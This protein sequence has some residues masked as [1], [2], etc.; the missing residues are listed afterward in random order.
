MAQTRQGSGRLCLALALAAS[1]LF[2]ASCATGSR[3][4]PATPSPSLRPSPAPTVAESNSAP[5]RW[6]YD[7]TKGTGQRDPGP[8]FM[9]LPPGYRIETVVS[10]LR[11]PTSIAFTPDGRLL[12]AQQSGAIRVV[13]DGRLRREPWYVVDAYIPVSEQWFAELGLVG[14]TV[15]PEFEENGYVYVY[16]TTKEPERRTVLA[17][18][19]DE[20]GRGV[21]LE[22][23][24]SLEAA[25]ECC[26]IAGSLRFAPDGSLFV[27]VGDHQLETEA[28]NVGSPFGAALRI[29]REGSAR[30][31]NPFVNRRGADARVYAYGLRNAYD[32]AIDPAT[33]RMF[34]TENGFAGQDAIIELKAGANYGWPGYELAVPLAQVEPPLIFYHDPIG[35]SGAEFYRDEALPALS[36]SL[37]FCQFHQGGALHA[38]TFHPD[39]TVAQDS[40]I[41]PGC[42]SDVLT[43]PNGFVYFVDY[44][45]GVVYRIAAGGH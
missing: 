9:A 40:I 27:M 13:E 32:I 24:F 5:I 18:I 30:R 14:I 23:I 8:R 44:V 39:G 41:A 22:E 2:L 25:P 37:L 17:R 38:V 10:R 45:G 6:G 20:K 33:G 3:G 19:R 1:V 34:A 12:V 4:A 42:T 29:D 11:R 35:P 21:D 28:Q 16:Y 15:D 36:G 31:D 7:P 26:H 43:G